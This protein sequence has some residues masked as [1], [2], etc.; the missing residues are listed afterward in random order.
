MFPQKYIRAAH[1]G[2]G[3]D[4]LVLFP[5]FIN[6]NEMAA[7]LGLSPKEVVSAGF[8][9]SGIKNG[10]ISFQCYGKSTS[11]GKESLME[12]TAL[13]LRQHYSHLNG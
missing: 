6:H 2:E 11:L 1:L 7:K 10:D 13:L 4:V 8:V 5:N 9:S 12:D 3:T